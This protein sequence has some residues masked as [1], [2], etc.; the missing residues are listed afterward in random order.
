MSEPAATMAAVSRRQTSPTPLVGRAPEL[1]VLRAALGRAAAGDA[2]LVLV[3]GEAGVGK[4]R[5]L[6]ELIDIGRGAGATVLVGH[7]LDIGEVGLPYL[8]FTEALA[9]LGGGRDGPVE[10]SRLSVLTAPVTDAGQLRVFES[11]L[12]LLAAAGRTGAGPVLLILEDLH[13]ADRSS[14][15]LLAFLIARS[16][17]DRLL[18]VASYR[19]DGVDRG[20]ALRPL[21]AQLA[22]S[23]VVEQVSLAGL[24]DAEMAAYLQGCAGTAV[25]AADVQRIVTRSAGNA[26]YAR[27]L[28]ESTD[29]SGDDTLPRPLAEL[30]LTRLA[31]LPPDGQALAR[32]VAAGGPR[33]RHQALAGVAG[34]PDPTLELALQSS[35]DH[36][37]LVSAGEDGYAFAHALLGEAVYADLLPGERVRL[38]AAWAR[39]L[40]AADP[41]GHPLGSAA[42]VA[43]HRMCSHDIPGALTASVQAAGE[44][45]GLDAPGEA[46]Q[47]WERA[48][49]LWSALA[50]VRDGTDPGGDVTRGVAARIDPVELGLRA[51]AMASRA[52]S[53]HR[54]VALAQAAAQRLDIGADPERAAQVYQRLAAHL[55]DAERDGEALM[56]AVESERLASQVTEAAVTAWSAAATATALRHLKRDDEA[57]AAAERARAIAV[58]TATPAAEADALLTL[59]ILDNRRGRTASVAALLAQAGE[60]AALGG[61]LA[62]ELRLSYT[63][64]ADRYESGDVTGA[65]DLLDTVVARSAQRGMTWSP[66]GLEL[67]ALEVTARFVVGDWAGSASAAHPSGPEPPEPAAARIAATSLYVAVAAGETG[68]AETVARLDDAWHHDVMVGMLTGGAAS[69][70]ARWRGDSAGALEAAGRVLR[71]LDDVAQPWFLGGIWVCALALGAAGDLAERAR[72][73]RD[74]DLARRTA[75]RADELLERARSTARLGQPRGGTLGPEGS[76]WLARAEAEHTRATGSSSPTRWQDAADR[77]AYGH[78]YEQARSRWRLAEALLATGARDAAVGHARAAHEVAVQLGARPLRDAVRALARRGRLELAPRGAAAGAPGHPDAEPGAGPLTVREHDVL[79]LLADGRTNRQVGEVLFMAEKTASVHV[80]R[81]LAKLGATSRAEAVSRAYDRGLL[82][83]RGR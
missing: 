79:L 18:V 39:A 43:H 47:Q 83:G 80:S 7:C 24:D 8:P 10:T 67:Q 36:H 60:R 41:A 77:F 44:A 53:G 1:G 51:A 31:Q 55:A 13:W 65:L 57:R 40:Q 52:G 42:E 56:A 59:A 35:V 38:H 75:L 76:A 17:G 12:D 28:W 25:D 29:R 82:G 62:V 2:G 3:A 32:A 33:V 9:P 73:V 20:H 11:V 54:A 49:Q 70:L 69:E 78:R 37:V 27:E 14:R 64:A 71:H 81:I 46:W 58:R 45:E 23:P 50:E 15:D 74:P 5:L 19:T 6:Q 34:L 30:L 4:T 66:W 48:L 16:R 22:R 26:Y 68:A 63:L 61:D 72:L 21:L